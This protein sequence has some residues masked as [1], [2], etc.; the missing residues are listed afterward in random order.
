MSQVP[1]C[2]LSVPCWAPD[3]MNSSLST[4]S[5]STAYVAWESGEDEP[6][7]PGIL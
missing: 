3:L 6:G 4:H 5:H 2:S 1:P 7:Q